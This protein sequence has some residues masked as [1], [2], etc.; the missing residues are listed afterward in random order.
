[1]P[2]REK[3]RTA[4]ACARHVPS[5]VPVYAQSAAKPRASPPTAL[6]FTAETDS[7]LEEDGFELPVPML[8]RLLHRST[9]VTSYAVNFAVDSLLE[10]AVMSEPVSEV[11]FPGYWEKYRV[12]QPRHERALS[13]LLRYQRLTSSIP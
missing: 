10:E 2:V 4:P 6:E 12:S 9:V 8:D 13:N 11:R 3:G 5:L 7:A 1:M